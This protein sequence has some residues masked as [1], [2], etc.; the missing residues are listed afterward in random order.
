MLAEALFHRTDFAAPA[1][2]GAVEK[3]R[4]LPRLVET[5]AYCMQPTLHPEAAPDAAA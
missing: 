5:V 4:D 2:A 3:S 1:L